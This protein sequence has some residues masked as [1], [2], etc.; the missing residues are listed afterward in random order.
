[1]PT[2]T[3]KKKRIAGKR[4]AIIILSYGTPVNS[5]IT[6]APAPIKGGMICPPDEATASTAADNLFG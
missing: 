2:Q 5:T 3:A 1:M 4:A 6:N